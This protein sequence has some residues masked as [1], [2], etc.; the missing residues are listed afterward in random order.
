LYEQKVLKDVGSMTNQEEKPSYLG[1]QQVCRQGGNSLCGSVW[2]A[3]LKSFF[4]I[5][6]MIFLETNIEVYK[7]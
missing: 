7:P 1:H 5:L 3:T 6:L 4:I 2:A